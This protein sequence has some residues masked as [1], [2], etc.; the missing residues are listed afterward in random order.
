MQGLD[1]ASEDA[2][3]PGETREPRSG[4]MSVDAFSWR[5]G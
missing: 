3:N 2:P 4:G 5:W 1:S